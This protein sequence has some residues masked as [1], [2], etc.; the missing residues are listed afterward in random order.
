MVGPLVGW[1]NTFDSTTC[2]CLSG[3]SKNETTVAPT[4]ASPTCL[5]TRNNANSLN[6]KK[7]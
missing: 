3:I 2:T 4:L 1:Q 7:Y 5:H 6:N